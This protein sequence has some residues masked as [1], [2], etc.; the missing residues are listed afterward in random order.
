MQ[1]WQRAGS[2]QVEGKA[3]WTLS[4]LINSRKTSLRDARVVYDKERHF[5]LALLDFILFGS[6]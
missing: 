1:C 2:F 6:I 3:F 4:R 5:S